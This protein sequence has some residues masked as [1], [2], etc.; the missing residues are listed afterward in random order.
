[1]LRATTTSAEHVPARRGRRR[2]LAALIAVIAPVA[3]V[4]AAVTL[5]APAANAAVP[6]PPAGW[7]TVFSDDF[8]G[9]ANTGVSGNWIYDTGPGSSF[10]PTITCMPESSG[11]THPVRKIRLTSPAQIGLAIL[12]VTT[13]HHS[14][15]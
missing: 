5:A 7:S 9:A 2:L 6:A 12:A 14:G 4:T 1:M 11:C 10:A 3:A 13:P 8:N 15:C